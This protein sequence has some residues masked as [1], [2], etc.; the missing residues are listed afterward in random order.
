MNVNFAFNLFIAVV[1]S[2]A[3][4]ENIRVSEIINDI[5]Q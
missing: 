5:I 1:V 3:E 4:E 2:G